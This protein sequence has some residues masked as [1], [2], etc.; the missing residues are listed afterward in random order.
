[1]KRLMDFVMVQYL[2]VLGLDASYK[3]YGYSR[4]PETQERDSEKH[5]V[6]RSCESIICYLKDGLLLKLKFSHGQFTAL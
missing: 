6:E 1:M 2:L 3:E 5:S 4:E